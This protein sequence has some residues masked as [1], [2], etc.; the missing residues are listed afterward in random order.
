MIKSKFKNVSRKIIALSLSAMLLTASLPASSF[1]DVIDGEIPVKSVITLGRVFSNY[2][3]GDELSSDEYRSF[4]GDL[5]DTSEVLRAEFEMNKRQLDMVQKKL[6]EFEEETLASLTNYKDL[7]LKFNERISFYRMVKDNFVKSADMSLLENGSTQ[8][9]HTRG[10]SGDFTKLLVF[11]DGSWELID[12][13]EN[14]EYLL[15]H[16]ASDGYA[17]VKMQDDLSDPNMISGKIKSLYL[18]EMS[19]FYTKNGYGTI[20]DESGYIDSGKWEENNEMSMHY[21]YNPDEAY[22]AITQFQNGIR[23]G[24]SSYQAFDSEDVYTRIYDKDALHGLALTHYKIDGIEAEVMFYYDQDEKLPL[25]YINYPNNDL[26]RM[27]IGEENPVEIYDSS[28]YDRLIVSHFEDG[29]P[30]GFGYTRYGQVEYIGFFDGFDILGDGFYY[31][32]DDEENVFDAKVDAVIDEIIEKDMTDRQKLLAIHDYIVNNVNY[33]KPHLDVVDQPGFTH[34]AYGALMKG[35]AVCDG[36][37]QAFKVLTD[38]VGIDNRLIFGITVDG[39]GVFQDYNRHAWNIVKYNGEYTHF[40]TTWDDPTY[41]D[42]IR[43]KYYFI[44]SE[45]IS[46]DHKWD[47]EKYEIY[48]A[49]AHSND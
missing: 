10:D 46:K 45:E 37:A 48:F 32:I 13:I 7:F 47:T 2:S 24:I 35:K 49:P 25:V 29:R 1:A 9:I 30:T 11:P 31:H 20:Y 42:R 22:K 16:I 23:N 36:Y 3:T 41:S 4:F 5:V 26:K 27:I 40:D 8:Y 18:G 12:C 33:H 19:D 28:K 43:H 39:K 44:D 14:T 38:R 21:I 34:T 15:A 17:S 6:D